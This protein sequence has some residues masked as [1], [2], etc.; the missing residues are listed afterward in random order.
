LLDPGRL[1]RG[2]APHLDVG[3]PLE[4]G[5]EVELV[6]DAAYPDAAGRPLVAPTTRRFK[7][8]PSLR[9]RVDPARWRLTPPRPRS[10]DPLRVAFDRPLDHALAARCLEVLDAASRPVAGSTALAEGERGWR[11]VPAL[12]WGLGHHRLIVAPE[13][14]DVAG[15]SVIRPFDRDLSR[16]E[17]DPA[18]P[19]AVVL[20]FLGGRRQEPGDRPEVRPEGGF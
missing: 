13:L 5:R 6:V 11:F 17:D 15:N 16:P 1:K 12:P 7:V 18:A 3:Y 19:G 14:E 9:G 20:S 10:A 8:A 4:P 2:L